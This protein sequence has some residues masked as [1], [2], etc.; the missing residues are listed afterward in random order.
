MKKLLIFLL[1]LPLIGCNNI[2]KDK[3]A[4]ISF[5]CPKVFF[6]ADDRNFI[7]SSTSLD[8]VKI[9]AEINNFAFN[10]KCQQMKNVVIIPLDILIVV[11]LMDN[12][13][14]SLINFPVYVSL[15]DEKDNVLE[16]QYFLISD[17]ME[18]NI[19]SNKSLEIDVVERLEIISNNL[20]TSQLILGFMLDNKKRVL[21]N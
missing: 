10:K 5:K 6:S 12:K 2:L 9:K 11:K 21:L 20:N 13:E 15:L 1:F 17:E 16:T 18:V 4:N 3:Q 14:N 8:D 7:D 19:D